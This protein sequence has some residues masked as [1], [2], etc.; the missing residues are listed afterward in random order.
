MELPV[1]F[2][3]LASSKKP[4]NKL[5][6]T[7]KAITQHA[8]RSGAQPLAGRGLNIN[9]FHMLFLNSA[10]HLQA[11]KFSHQVTLKESLCRARCCPTSNQLSAHFLNFALFGHGEGGSYP[12]EWRKLGKE[13]KSLFSCIY[14]LEGMMNFLPI[15]F[16]AFSLF[17][18]EPRQAS[19]KQIVTQWP[20]LFVS[21]QFC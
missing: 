5:E 18:V 7:H 3:S 8:Q 2:T 19:V 12:K 20:H 4:L 14:F 11:C 9:L 1:F 21:F 16:S 13:E 10:W 6:P 17:G 15:F